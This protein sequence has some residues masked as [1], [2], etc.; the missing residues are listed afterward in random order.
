MVSSRVCELAGRQYRRGP[1]LLFFSPRAQEK[2]RTSNS[3]E[4]VNREVKRRSRVAVLFPNAESA[5]RLVT[6]VLEIHEEWI[7]GKSYL[8][9][10]LGQDE[11]SGL[12]IE[13]QQAV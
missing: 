3:L 12:K 6:G 2:L 1:N 5:L 13:E 11:K 10:S 8:D 9:M 4:R 7:T